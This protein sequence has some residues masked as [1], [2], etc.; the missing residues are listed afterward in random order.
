[1]KRLRE[2]GKKLAA[3]R[4]LG[5]AMAEEG[6]RNIVLCALLPRCAAQQHS[7]SLPEPARLS[8]PTT[9]DNSQGR[10]LS[11]PSAHCRLTERVK[12]K[13]APRKCEVAGLN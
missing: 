13:I 6:P 1:M 5:R 11:R 9:H 2:E 8:A 3:E 12:V 7:A 10:Q 4:R